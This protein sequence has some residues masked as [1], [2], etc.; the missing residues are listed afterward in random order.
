ME[1]AM[2]ILFSHPTPRFIYSHPPPT[3]ILPLSFIIPSPQKGSNLRRG[4]KPL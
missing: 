2:V 1:T 4:A 3:G